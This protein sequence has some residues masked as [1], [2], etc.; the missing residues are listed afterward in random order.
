MV[1]SSALVFG[2]WLVFLEAVLDATSLI[3]WSDGNIYLDAWSV[4]YMQIFEG[5]MLIYDIAR[6]LV[7]LWWEA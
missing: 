4:K 1:S 7:L 6:Y 2:G 3:M 5:M